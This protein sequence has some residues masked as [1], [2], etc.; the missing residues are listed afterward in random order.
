MVK[1]KEGCKEGKEEHV[2]KIKGCQTSSSPLCCRVSSLL[3]FGTRFLVFGICPFLF[4]AFSVAPEMFLPLS[5]V[6]LGWPEGILLAH[7]RATHLQSSQIVSPG[8]LLYVIFP[9]EIFS[10]GPC[11]RTEQPSHC[12][13]RAMWARNST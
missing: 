2:R 4:R 9:T 13:P 7:Y 11:D 1:W 3:V 6:P 12:Q 8:S 10:L 5:V